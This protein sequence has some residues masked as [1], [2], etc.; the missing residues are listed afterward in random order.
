[1]SGSW[2]RRSPKGAISPS[3]DDRQRVLAK[4][5]V[6][7]M[8]HVFLQYQGFRL[9]VES[10][11][12]DEGMMLG[13]VG[14]NS[15]GKTSLLRILAGDIRPSAGRIEYPKL[16]SDPRDW[17]I[18]KQQIGYVQQSPEH[19]PG[20]AIDMLRFE[21]AACGNLGGANETWVYRWVDRLR[22]GEHVNKT[23]EQLSGGFKTRFELAKALMRQPQ[24]LILDEPLA[25][26]DPAA[27]ITLLWD[28]Q[29]FCKDYGLAIAISSQHLHEVEAF[30]HDVL[31]LQ[32][33]SISKFVPD[34]EGHFEIAFDAVSDEIRALM[35]S[36]DPRYRFDGYV[37][38]VR[39]M[40]QNVDEIIA[41][42][43]NLNARTTYYRDIS[44][45]TARLFR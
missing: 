3:I 39:G 19:W 7:A 25:A 21:A 33:G 12:I 18:L 6:V 8:S 13:F 16:G 24:L 2:A 28:L 41:K 4:G 27:Q 22:L 30:A 9:F 34:G 38:H 40:P 1:M 11:K 15:S 26:L 20:L 31:F 42:A 32:D 5:P 14:A 29:V 17:Y 36:I 43:R 45:S 44:T 10:L 37:F 23:W 35:K